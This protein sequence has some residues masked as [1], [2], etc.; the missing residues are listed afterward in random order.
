MIYLLIVNIAMAIGFG[1]YQLFFRKLTFFQWNRYYLL[2]MVLVSLLIPI[3]IFID[4][5]AF[6]AQQEVLPTI[7]FT[8]IDDVV[9]VVSNNNKPFYLLD[10]LSWIYRIGIGGIT[11]FFLYRIG[12]IRKAMQQESDYNSFS[13]FRNIVLG[14]KVKHIQ[15]IN[16]HEQI[17]VQQGHSYD[18]IFMELVCI[19]N[20]FN[21]IVYYIKKELKFQ[22]ECI[23]DEICSTDKVSYAE[24]LLA[25]AMKTNINM[26]RHEFS[27]QSFLKKR[28]M[29]LFKNKS[30]NKKRYLY[31][32]ALP[33]IAVVALS[34]LVFNTSKAKDV[35]KEIENKIEDVK[36]PIRNI[37]TEIQK[38]EVEIE[39]FPKNDLLEIKK[40]LGDTVAVPVNSSEFAAWCK[41]KLIEKDLLN[42]YYNTPLNMT[43]TVNSSGEIKELSVFNGKNEELPDVV[44]AFKVLPNWLPAMRNGKP[45]STEAKFMIIFSEKDKLIISNVDRVKLSEEEKEAIRLKV[46]T[47][48]GDELFSAVDINPEP[49]GG[50]VAFRK[51]IGDNYKYP[52]AAIDA[53]V[54]GTIHISFIVEKDGSLSDLKVIKDPGHGLGMAAIEL[55]KTSP[56]WNMGIQNGRAVRVQYTLPIKVDLSKE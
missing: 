5:S 51:W 32:S 13:F 21:P 30:T 15:E 7:H 11:L 18:I 53:G 36:L 3:G 44:E 10:I 9:I 23:A 40:V 19:F 26:L 22:H 55:L 37:K 47:N 17:H 20:W 12:K 39:V 50:M 6:F 34:T 42:K 46:L 56:K 43:F 27:N 31:L 54:K 35:V 1:L 24:L 4:L 8:V 25:H 48:T 28:I 14:S 16:A 49:R 33:L 45:I 52:Q 38:S 41:D 2:G 29:M